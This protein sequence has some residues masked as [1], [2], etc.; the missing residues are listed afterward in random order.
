IADLR[1]PG[2]RQHPLETHLIG[3]LRNADAL[4]VVW[5]YEVCSYV[6][7]AFVILRIIVVC[8]HMVDLGHFWNYGEC[9]VGELDVSFNLSVVCVNVVDF[10]IEGFERRD[11][12][13]LRYGCGKG[14][15]DDLSVGFVGRLY[16]GSY[17]SGRS[18]DYGGVD[19]QD[20]VR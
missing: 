4:I 15:V 8:M 7:R 13:F 16:R 6:L 10:V 11:V 3:R 17:D 18:R 1:Q 9:F 2:S 19:G 14:L 20:R 12:G 5:C